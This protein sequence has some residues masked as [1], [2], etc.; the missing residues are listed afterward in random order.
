MDIPVASMRVF[1][2]TRHL[3]SLA[4]KYVRILQADATYKLLWLGFP[5][6]IIGIS[7][8]NKIFHPI[9]IALCKDE[10]TADFAFIFNSLVIGINRCNL[11]E[12]NHV[13][14]LADAADS[15]TNGFR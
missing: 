9:G 2:S 14:L 12:L 8:M 3:L 15:I 10:K 4:S 1:I 5:V 11:P 13:D 6:L 7:D